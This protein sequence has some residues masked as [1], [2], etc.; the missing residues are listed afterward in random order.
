MDW[1]E[2]SNRDLFLSLFLHHVNDIKHNTKYYT[3]H[4]TV[5]KNSKN[6]IAMINKL[7]TVKTNKHCIITISFD[8]ALN[9]TVMNSFPKTSTESC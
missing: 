1:R 7:Q 5:Y 3:I 2:D 4:D 9:Y 8:Y 6:K